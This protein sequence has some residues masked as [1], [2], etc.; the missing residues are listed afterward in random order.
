MTKRVTGHDVARRAGVT[1]ATVSRAL[2]NLPGT[3]R[4]T[5][6]RVLRAAAELAYIPSEN[7]RSLS[8]ART[9]RV[10]VVSDALTNPY[11]PQLV[12][13]LRRHL[14]SRDLQMVLVTETTGPAGTGVSL[15]A[16]ADGSYDGVILTTTTRTSS[17]PR[18][19]T[20]R[21]I[22]HV[23][24]NRVLDVPESPG[25][26]VDNTGGVMRVADL[27]V[28]AG[29]RRIAV[30]QGPTDTS[31]GRERATGFRAGLRRHGVPLPRSLVRRT[32]FDHDAAM[33]AAISLLH[34]PDPPTAV[35]GGND[36]IALGVLSA[37]TTLGIRVPEDLTV[38]GF[39]DIPMAGWPLVGLTTVHCDLDALAQV[40]VDLLARQLRGGAVAPETRRIPVSLVERRTH[41]PAPTR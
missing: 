7:A 36:V 23:L 31:T 39:D 11:Y 22:P 33:G 40:A 19:L 21:G 16:L 30:I 27:L 35:F 28:R 38:I 10:A 25:C 37:A 2:R 13:P 41:G 26:T 34:S 24:V 17:R 15:E 1:Q 8:N 20:E 32:V 14:G 12:E 9:R 3:S 6:Q 29:H 4:G 18:D 5:R